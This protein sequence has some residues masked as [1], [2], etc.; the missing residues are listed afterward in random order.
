M[1]NGL[2]TLVKTTH[3]YRGHRTYNQTGVIFK[4]FM[5]DDDIYYYS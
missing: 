4:S 2:L 3:K 1:L 5:N